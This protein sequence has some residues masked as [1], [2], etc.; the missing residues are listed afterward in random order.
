MHDVITE[1]SSF[2]RNPN[3]KELSV[4]RRK[5]THECTSSSDNFEPCSK[6][7]DQNRKIRSTRTDW[8]LPSKVFTK[9]S[10]TDGSYKLS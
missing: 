7:N 4:T 5:I 1:F 2:E 6:I 8:S 3:V 10:S 9:S